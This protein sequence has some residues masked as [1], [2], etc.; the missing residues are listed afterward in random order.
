LSGVLSAT[1]SGNGSN[2]LLDELTKLRDATSRAVQET[3][4]GDSGITSLCGAVGQ[5][6]RWFDA[7]ARLIAGSRRV[8]TAR[9]VII[10]TSNRPI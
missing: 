5:P 10:A 2:P 1:S 3:S 4:Q 8:A 6:Q 7:M 9:G